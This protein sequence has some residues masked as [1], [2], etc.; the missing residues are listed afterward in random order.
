MKISE[1]LK[2]FT[3]SAMLTVALTFLIVHP[4][5]FAAA[6]S[7]DFGRED[8]SLFQDLQSIQNTRWLI[9]QQE[10]LEHFFI[11]PFLQDRAKQMVLLSPLEIT[12]RLIE[13][14]KRVVNDFLNPM[15][16]DIVKKGEIHHALTFD[17]SYTDDEFS[18][19]YF[20][21]DEEE[22]V[23]VM[24]DPKYP[25]CRPVTLDDLFVFDHSH[26]PG[27]IKKYIAG[28]YT[29]DCTIG[30]F[31]KEKGAR[32][33][34]VPWTA[35][36]SLVR[37]GD[38]VEESKTTQKNGLDVSF[39]E[40]IETEC[41]PGQWNSVLHIEMQATWTETKTNP[42][43]SKE[44]WTYRSKFSKEW[45]SNEKSVTARDCGWRGGNPPGDGGVIVGNSEKEEVQ[46]Q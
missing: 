41:K 32:D 12:E 6:Q 26:T 9:K 16:E 13:L 19:S 3:T 22:E 30:K 31:A 23:A 34:D 38:E 39:S 43:G 21:F 11:D 5:M 25:Q 33:E 7:N 8:D 29:A 35:V 17:F 40:S 15:L 4:G 14:R 45:Q 18:L 20:A 28:R 44:T 27:T 1:K 46:Y 37:Y 36:F 42:D 10:H 24:M 2:Q